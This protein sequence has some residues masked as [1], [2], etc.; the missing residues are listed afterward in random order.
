VELYDVYLGLG[1]K[2]SKRSLVFY[3][4]A[5]EYATLCEIQIGTRE[6]FEMKMQRAKLR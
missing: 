6:N 1:G 3:E 2:L 5:L 4:F